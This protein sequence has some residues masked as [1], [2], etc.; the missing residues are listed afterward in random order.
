MLINEILKKIRFSS[1]ADRI[2][3]DMPFSH[4]RL[5]FTGSMTQLCKRK[6]RS[7]GEGSEF[8]PGAYAVGC[9]RI[10]IGKRVII[11]PGTMLFGESA[12]LSESII[13]EDNVMLGCGVHIYINNHAFD[14]VDIPIIDQDY[15]PDESV[16]LMDGCWVGANSIL[17]PGVT[18]GRNSVIGAGSIVTRS[19][20]NGVIAVGSPAK[21]IREIDQPKK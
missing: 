13:I 18:I 9:S 20:P 1:S 15:Y 11:R 6:F 19:V 16:R 8:R 4:W 14:R 21:I 10:M 3:P 2:G 7:F 5:Y 12:S 17:L